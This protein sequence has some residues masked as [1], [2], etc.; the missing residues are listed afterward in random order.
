MEAM[1]RPQESHKECTPDGRGIGVLVSGSILIIRKCCSETRPGAER[2]VVPGASGCRSRCGSGAHACNAATRSDAQFVWIPQ[3]FLHQ[4]QL[5]VDTA[6]NTFAG[7]FPFWRP[8]PALRGLYQ[9]SSAK[10]FGAGWRTRPFE[11]TALDCL[12]Y[13]RSLGESLDWNDYLPPSREKQ[14][15]DA[16][17]QRSS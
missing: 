7:N 10:A 8:D 16:W 2:H 12:I 15:L 11:E 4:H 14:V 17:A 9:I 3:G 13:Y 1:H 6:L 5:E